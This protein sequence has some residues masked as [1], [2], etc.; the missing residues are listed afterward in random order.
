MT[1]ECLVLRVPANDLLVEA[2]VRPV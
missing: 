1:R 2:S